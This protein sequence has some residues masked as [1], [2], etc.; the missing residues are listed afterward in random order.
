MWENAIILPDTEN[1]AVAR[2][3]EYESALQ[4]LDDAGMVRQVFRVGSPG[5]PLKAYRDFSAFKL[6]VHDVGLLGAMS[7]LSPSVLLEGNALFTNFKGALTEQ[8]ALQELLAAVRPVILVTS[9]FM[10]RIIHHV[11]RVA[12]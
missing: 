6:Y 8:Y 11:K 7:G 12:E 2:A 3:R 1:L 9:V 4:W 5:L 10:S